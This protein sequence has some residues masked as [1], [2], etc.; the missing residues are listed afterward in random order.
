MV[1]RLGK[2]IL[3]GPSHASVTNA[4]SRA[5]RVSM[6]VARECN[7]AGREE[8]ERVRHTL[9]V[10][11]HREN[12]ETAAFKHLLEKPEDVEGAGGGS[13]FQ[14]DLSRP[15]WLLVLLESNA[16]GIPEL[17]PDDSP[18]LHMMRRNMARRSELT[19]LFERA[20][21]RISWEDYVAKASGHENGIS[22]LFNQLLDIADVLALT[23]ALS[24]NDDKCQKWKTTKARGVLVDEAANMNRADFICVSGNVLLPC[25][26]IGD[27]KQLPPTVM[28]AT[29]KDEEGF[30]FHRLSANGLISPLDFAQGFGWPVHRLHVQLRMARGNFDLVGKEIYPELPF[31]YGASC[32]VN[33]PPFAIGRLLED[34]M[35][36]R[37]PEL[38]PTAPGTFNPVFLHVPNA[39]VFRRGSS[40]SKMCPIQVR[41]ALTIAADFADHAAK[42]MAASS[43]SIT[44]L[45]PYTA[46]V[47]LITRER[48]KE[49]FAKVLIDMPPPSTIDSY[50]G[51]ENDVIIIVMGTTQD[52][53][54]GFTAQKNRLNVLLTRA[55]CAIVIVGDIEAVEEKD[56]GKGKGKAKAKQVAVDYGPNGESL[57]MNVKTIREVYRQ[58]ARSGRVAKMAPKGDVSDG[59]ED[60]ENRA[61]EAREGD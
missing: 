8:Q 22:S 42:E 27:P 10:R 18:A 3:S 26:L 7:E 16:K 48:R 28:S 32:D 47:D 30:L 55:R 20:Q 21:G 14:L 12:V 45:S 37:Y 61:G 44:M 52:S 58:L 53:R 57:F 40:K 11:V 35:R 31:S 51:Q 24:Q 19:P 9:V 15:Y 4:A 38:K 2:I 54:P 43:R 23:P 39:R 25:F 29:E 6:G 34:F 46:N 50:Q 1:A 59:E 5:Y 41:Q 36:K 13:K 17:H 56:K 33:L 60:V 49:R